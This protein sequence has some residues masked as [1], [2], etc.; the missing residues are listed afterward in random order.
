MI[1]LYDKVE[2]IL[3]LNPK[4]STALLIKEYFARHTQRSSEEVALFMELLEEVYVPS[5]VRM[6]A[7]YRQNLGVRD[8]V[9]L[10]LAEAERRQMSQAPVLEANPPKIFH[11]LFI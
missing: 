3:R 8:E 7:K 10:T 1:T 2:E 6:A 5:I 4:M 9:R 11:D